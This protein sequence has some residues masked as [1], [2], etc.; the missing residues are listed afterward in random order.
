MKTFNLSR[1]LVLAASL[2]LAAMSQ[3]ASAA[4]LANATFDTDSYIFIGTNNEFQ[5]GISLFTDYS[6][7]VLDSLANSHFNFGVVK[8]DN[9][10]GLQTV[11]NGGPSKFLTLETMQSGSGVFGVSVAGA[12]IHNGYPTTSG[13]FNGPNGTADARLQWYFDNIK[14]DNASYGGYAGGADHLGVLNVAGMP[15]TYSLDVTAVVDAWLDGSVPNYG[16][17]LWAASTT[18]AQG[19]DLDFASLEN[20]LTGGGYFGPRLTSNAIPEPASVGLMLVGLAAWSLT[21]KRR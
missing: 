9:L 16:F 5:T 21:R 11:A 12:D 6:G 19:A 10:A 7:G 15:A 13:S 4:I 20:P 17:G 3:S 8:F 14:G 1:R 2:F 18:G